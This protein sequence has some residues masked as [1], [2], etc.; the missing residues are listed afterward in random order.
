MIDA[1]A[2]VRA[3]LLPPLF[4]LCGERIYTGR[5]DPPPGYEPDQ[6]PAITM[7][8]RGGQ[9]GYEDEVYA[10]SWQVQCYGLD[11]STAYSCY[12][13]LHT[14]LHGVSTAAILHAEEEVAG[15][16]LEE[17]DTGWYFTLSYWSIVLRNTED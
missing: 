3:A 8:V 9:P 14:A 11:A 7:R 17:E 1:N 16:T 15:Q 6:G 2:I 10:L 4:A 12:R 5:D 13:A